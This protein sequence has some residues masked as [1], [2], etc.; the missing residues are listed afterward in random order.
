[1]PIAAAQRARRLLL[2][3][4]AAAL[5]LLG[6]TLPDQPVSFGNVTVT[7]EAIDKAVTGS[8]I[9]VA[10]VLAGVLFVLVP[11]TRR[12]ALAINTKLFP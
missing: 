9:M 11:H 10:L 3:S 12:I 1:M 2:V 4:L 5:S 8:I 7:P 6:A